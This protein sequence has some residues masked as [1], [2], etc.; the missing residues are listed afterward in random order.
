MQRR[1]GGV[2]QGSTKCVGEVWV[3]SM[4]DGHQSCIHSIVSSIVTSSYWC[5]EGLSLLESVERGK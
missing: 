4:F 1:T 3:N 2:V 5:S